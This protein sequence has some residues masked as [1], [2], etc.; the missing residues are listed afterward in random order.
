V[1]GRLLRIASRWF[2]IE[3]LYRF[4]AKFFPRWAPRYLVYTGSTALPA[5]GLAVL[6]LEGQLP[7]SLTHL[8]G[9]GA[10]A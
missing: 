7:R 6:A 8:L 10:P 9:A 2:Q 4:N 1:L 5:V 3:S